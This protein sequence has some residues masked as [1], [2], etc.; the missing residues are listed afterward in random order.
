[1]RIGD[2]AIGDWVIGGKFG[3]LA[4]GEIGTFVRLA[5][6]DSVI[7]EEKRAASAMHWAI[8]CLK[9]M[10]FRSGQECLL[11]RR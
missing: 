4:I 3:D 8:A 11:L 6:G 1:M 2:W 10:I 7:F 5:V 9:Q